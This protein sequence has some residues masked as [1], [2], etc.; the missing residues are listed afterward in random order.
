MR[1]VVG[2]LDLESS[3]LGEEE[4]AWRPGLSRQPLLEHVRVC[5]SLSGGERVRGLPSCSDPAHL[6]EAHTH[7][8]CAQG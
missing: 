3:I 1:P 4:G 5:L 7:I 6:W 8:A 2:L